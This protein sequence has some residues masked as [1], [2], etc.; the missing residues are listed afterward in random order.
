LSLALIS[1]IVLAFLSGLSHGVF[2]G[3][4]QT[5]EVIVL[6]RVG[7]LS[8][9]RTSTKNLL[10]WRG[11]NGL[12]GRLTFFT[13]CLIARFGSAGDKIVRRTL[14][15]WCSGAFT[16]LHLADRANVGEVIFGSNNAALAFVGEHRLS[17]KLHVALATRGL[18]ND[19]AG[20]TSFLSLFSL[21]VKCAPSLTDAISF[22]LL[23][24]FLCLDLFSV[25]DGG[26]V[27]SEGKIGLFFVRGVIGLCGLLFGFRVDL[28]LF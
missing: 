16:I 15:F 1:L 21:V 13:G 24:T 9:V 19:A 23:A 28:G 4:T 8:K 6:A 12:R 10:L 14:V 27:I 20:D 5:S 17:T 26:L 2:G 3:R 11:K 25:L 7:N 18:P 22:F